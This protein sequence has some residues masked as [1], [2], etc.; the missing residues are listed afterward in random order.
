MNMKLENDFRFVKSN[1]LASV[2]STRFVRE[3]RGILISIA[4]LALH[5]ACVG[6]PMT[7]AGNP[8]EGSLN[9]F[10][11]EPFF[12][13]ETLFGGVGEITRGAHMVIAVDGSLVARGGAVLRRSEDGGSTWREL[14][15]GPI[16]H[17]VDENTGDI[18]SLVLNNRAEGVGVMRSSDNGRTWQGENAPLELSREILEYEKRT[19]G[20]RSRGADRGEES[21]NYWMHAGANESGITLRHGE[22]KGRLMHA[23]TFRPHSSLHPSDRVG[24][25]LS[26]ATILYS[27]DAGKSWHVGGLF[28]DG[29]TEESGVAELS[30]G[31]I[32]FD[33]RSS[34]GYHDRS[35]ARDLLPE[36]TLRR[37]AWSSD[38]GDTWEDLTISPVLPDGGGYSRGYGLRG[39]IV[40]LPVAGRDILIYSNT[41]TGGGEREKMTVWASFDGGKSWPVKR[42]VYPGPSA[43][44]T[45]DAGRPG[46]VGEGLIFLLFEGAETHRYHGI[47]FA[48]F[49]LS[50]LLEG[51]MTGDG[52]I[53]GWV[54]EIP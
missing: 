2:G 50:W 42:L 41:D 54:F 39:G 4:A 8:A 24:E 47:Q 18:L 22:K 20:Q 51:E 25:E 31:R 13:I 29:H 6:Q 35:F 33:A 16:P 30:D 36:E 27:D 46:T 34:S 7:A 44:S 21:P 11:E 37:M 5:A 43:Y 19:G 9:P 40:R 23:A 48:R 52:G 14:G 3:C 17:L 12:E 26:Y 38:Y 15:G 45:L 10:L 32:Y 28:P 53:P 49:N 1:S